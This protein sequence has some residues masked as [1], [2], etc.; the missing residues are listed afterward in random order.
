MMKINKEKLPGWY[1]RM[2]I[3][4]WNFWQASEYRPSYQRQNTTYIM[5]KHVHL[6]KFNGRY[7]QCWLPK[8][9][10]LLPCKEGILDLLLYLDHQK[11]TVQPYSAES[12]NNS[13]TLACSIIL[14][15][16]TD[17]AMKPLKS[18][19]VSFQWVWRNQN[20]IKFNKANV[21]KQ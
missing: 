7:D 11:D 18:I 2:F 21:A 17:D 12:T 20:W 3:A 19:S 4:V 14:W 6:T 5:M 16:H 9:Y 10:F 15:T 8:L 13:F 1:P